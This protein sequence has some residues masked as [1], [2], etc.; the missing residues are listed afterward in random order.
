[1]KHLLPLIIVVLA[2]C[3]SSPPPN[4]C[5]P[6]AANMCAETATKPDV[7]KA[8]A[9]LEA[10]VKYPAKRADI[11][12]ACADTPEFSSAEKQWIADNLP[13]GDYQSAEQTIKALRL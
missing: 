4:A 13:E 8:K 5:A 7:A 1:M 3:S 9:H 2:G 12:A 11:L 10:H 6:S